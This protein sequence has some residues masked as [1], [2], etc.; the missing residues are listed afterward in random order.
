MDQRSKKDVSNSFSLP[1]S[2]DQS[3]KRN[4]HLCHETLAR[5]RSYGSEGV[6]HHLLLGKQMLHQPVGHL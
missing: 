5:L 6:I 4:Q 3:L 2:I 1:N